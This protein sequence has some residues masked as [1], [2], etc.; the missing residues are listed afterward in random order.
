MEKF[1]STRFDLFGILI[2]ATSGYIIIAVVLIW[3]LYIGHK[4][5]IRKTDKENVLGQ[6]TFKNLPFLGLKIGKIKNFSKDYDYPPTS[7]EPN[8]VRVPI[9]MYHHIASLPE[10]RKTPAKSTEGNSCQ[11]LLQ[12]L[13]NLRPQNVL[14]RPFSEGHVELDLSAVPDEGDTF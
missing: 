9:L 13:E 7:Q 3:F 14:S 8:S 4:P 11:L 12:K 2:G 1:L 10:E 5:Q 6:S